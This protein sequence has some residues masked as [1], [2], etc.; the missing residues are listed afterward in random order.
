MNEYIDTAVL[1]VAGMGSRLRPLTNDMPKALVA[2]NGQSILERAVTALRAHGVRKYV[3]ATGYRQDSVRAAV[4]GLG[5]D[6]VFCHNP[7]FETTQNS[8]SLLHCRAAL[9]GAGFYKLD[10]DV[11]FDAQ[12]L[13]RLDRAVAELSVAVDGS[14]PLDAEAMKAVVD[15]QGHILK[16]GK[17]LSV[18]EAY[19][20]SIGI[21]RVATSMS[22]A[23]FEAILALQVSG[24]VDR[25]YE[26]VYSELILSGQITA[27][28]AD[29][30]DLSW[31]EVDN[32]QDLARAA[33]L[34]A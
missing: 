27:K 1:L 26:D 17:A 7:A 13:Q 24:V 12:V 25:Y 21:E 10:G 22:E 23:L 4:A 3:F 30:G 34:F 16:F 31:A 11:L 6:A 20:E 19:G 33:A 14:K 9:T 8:I 28:A 2:I 18:H 32:A 15:R 5:I 29:V